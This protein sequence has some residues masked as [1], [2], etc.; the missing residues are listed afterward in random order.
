MLAALLLAAAQTPLGSTMIAVALPS[1]S[2]DLSADLASATTWLVTSYFILTVVG[3]GP[4][5]RLA[6][7]LGRWRMLAA[8]LATLG[9]GACLG[10]L[11]P[12]LWLL[13]AGRCLMAIGGAMLTPAVLALIRVQVRPQSR[14]RVFGAYSATVGLSA[15][16]GLP[17]GGELVHQFGWRAIFAGAF[18][19]VA[20]A[21]LLLAAGERNSDEA[22]TAARPLI[23]A[24]RDFDWLGTLLLSCSL[25]A[26]SAG[27]PWAA[28]LSA[29]CAAG[30]IL[31]EWRIADP[32]VALRLM[33]SA[34]FGAASAVIFLQSL[35]LYGLL[36]LLPQALAA[37]GTAGD[38]AAASASGRIL[39]ALMIGLFLASLAGGFALERWGARTVAVGGA[40]A[41]VLG[42][43][44]LLFLGLGAASYKLLGALGLV[45]GGVGAAWTAAQ[46]S[47]MA[48]IDEARSGAAA[49]AISSCRYL[50]GIIGLL[51]LVNAT[52]SSPV[53]G[54]HVTVLVSVYGGAL[55]A[56]AVACAFL[57]ARLPAGS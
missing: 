38:A 34:V 16:L 41:A 49:G 30:F 28:A 32:V 1:I 2:R 19:M 36:Y 17:L 23:P 37:G 12:T 20:A 46:T 26:L 10:M 35:A 39:F 7:A 13:A 52:G 15:A 33:R 24:V 14:G 22:A 51:A 29:A 3:Q 54:R 42:T 45:G 44:C 47:A 5:G 53:D 8:G 9:F 56:S 48:A 55:L 57:P 6:D 4:G 31:R 25:V 11:A 27:S 50:G 18:V 40:I 21:A 43:G